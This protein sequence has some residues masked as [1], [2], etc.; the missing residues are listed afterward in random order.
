MINKITDNTAGYLS[1]FCFS[2]LSKFFSNYRFISPFKKLI[3]KYNQS[4]F[5]INIKQLELRAGKTIGKNFSLFQAIDLLLNTL[6]TNSPESKIDFSIKKEFSFF[7]IRLKDNNTYSSFTK[8]LSSDKRGFLQRF[9]V[10]IERVKLISG[11]YNIISYRD[12]KRELVVKIP[13]V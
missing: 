9:I 10:P 5:M 11:N 13:V 12:H 6:K 3:A 7:E 4:D 1:M 2:V 8:L